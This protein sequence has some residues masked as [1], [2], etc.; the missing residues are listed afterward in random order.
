MRSS[1]SVY[2]CIHSKWAKHLVGAGRPKTRITIILHILISL[3]TVY[4]VRMASPF[5]VSSTPKA[6][7]H[8]GTLR[9]AQRFRKSNKMEWTLAI[10]QTKMH[11]IRVIRLTQTVLASSI[12]KGL[13]K[14]K[15]RRTRNSSLCLANALWTALK[16]ATARA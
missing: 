2:Q 16:M 14:E 12:T 6:E 10:Q 5:Q 7:Q 3:P 9:N 4:T 1:S 13:E 11:C 15:T 8:H